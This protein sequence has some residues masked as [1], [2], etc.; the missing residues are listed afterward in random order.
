MNKIENLSIAALLSY[1]N[2]PFKIYEDNRLTDMF[3]SIKEN[4]IVTPIIVRPINS[5][6]YEIL[7]GHNRVN[8]AKE[9][10]LV[11]VPAIVRHDL[12][13]DEALLIVIET[14]LIQRS[15]SDLTHSEK[16]AV[17]GVH[18]SVLKHSGRRAELIKEVEKI[19]SPLGTKTKS[20]RDISG[21]Y[22][23]SK[24]TV[25]RYLRINKLIPEL[26]ERLDGGG[27][28]DK[29]AMRTAVSLPY[30][31]EKSEKK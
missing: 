14:N 11:D 4:G 27:I 7:S 19:L 23:L 21:D 26:K 20:I 5:G 29:L 24:N 10:G 18:Y 16:A 2:H 17:L 6:E 12:N 15:F 8:A 13:D 25:A 1:K 30:L 22:G 31:C 9:A 28:G 3:D